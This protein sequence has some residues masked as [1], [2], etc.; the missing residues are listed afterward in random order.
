MALVSTKPVFLSAVL[1]NCSYSFEF[2]LYSHLFF[3]LSH[4]F[5]TLVDFPVSLFSLLFAVQENVSEFLA[6]V[7]RNEVE[8]IELFFQC[9]KAVSYIL[10]ASAYC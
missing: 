8:N 5:F 10:L 2:A 9:H 7:D 4:F 6:M 3:A 1:P